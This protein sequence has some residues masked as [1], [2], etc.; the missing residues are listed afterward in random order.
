MPGARARAVAIMP[1]QA[2][3]GTVTSFQ[4]SSRAPRGYLY[5]YS[6][7][8]G[9]WVSSTPNASYFVQI[10]NDLT[11]VQLWKSQAGVTTSLGSLAGVAMTRRRSSGCGSGCR[12]LR[13]M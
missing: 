7:A 10:T 11:T 2:D 5:L 13:S 1:K 12:E 4:F 9:D 6:R 3:T 8:S